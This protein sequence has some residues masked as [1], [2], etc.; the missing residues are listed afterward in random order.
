LPLE[1]PHGQAECGSHSAR[2][3]YEESASSDAIHTS[4]RNAKNRARYAPYER[5]KGETQQGK[6]DGS[7]RPCNKSRMKKKRP[8][9][10]EKK[11][12]QAELGGTEPTKDEGERT[13]V[14]PARQTETQKDGQRSVE[15]WTEGVAE[16]SNSR[17]GEVDGNCEG[18]VENEQQGREQEDKHSPPDGAD[19]PTREKAIIVTNEGPPPGAMSDNAKNDIQQ[20]EKL[21]GCNGNAGMDGDSSLTLAPCTTEKQAP[22]P[23]RRP[24]A[25]SLPKTH[26][27]QAPES[28]E[29]RPPHMSPNLSGEPRRGGKCGDDEDNEDLRAKFTCMICGESNNTKSS[30]TKHLNERHWSFDCAI[31][32]LTT[33][34]VERC[35][36]CRDFCENAQEHKRVCKQAKIRKREEKKAQTLVSEVQEISA[37]TPQITGPVFTTPPDENGIRRRRWDKGERRSDVP[38]AVLRSIQETRLGSTSAPKSQRRRQGK[39]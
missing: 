36:D 11:L 27:K 4:L 6:E 18:G 14:D 21:G 29:L 17:N 7:T 15:D 38:T 16:R 26:D 34:K 12:N 13:G 25:P 1:T 39:N 5:H 2:R 24:L 20:R 8:K 28:D 3:R 35:R 9:G 31:F 32:Q 30:L 22:E 37:S 10:K 19:P 23:E 33:M